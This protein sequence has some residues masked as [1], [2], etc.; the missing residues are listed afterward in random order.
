MAKTEIQDLSVL[1][2]D[3]NV[4]IAKTLSTILEAFGVRK[5]ILCKTLG[6][7]EKKFYNSALDC[8]FVDFIMED[9]TGIE[10]IKKIRTNPSSKNNSDL[11]IILDTGVTDVNTIVMARDAGVTEVISKPFSPEQVLQK[12]DNAV[13]N[14][15]DFIDVDEFVG[16]NRRRRRENHTEWEGENDRRLSATNNQTE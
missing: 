15:R 10:F 11:P 1:I 6:E 3:S 5:I 16:P 12:L 13:N 9:R 14:R 2:V 8:V 7:A 4:F